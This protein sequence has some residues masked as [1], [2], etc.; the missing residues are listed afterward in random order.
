MKITPLSR[1]VATAMVSTVFTIIVT[2]TLH[3]QP[4][5]CDTSITACGCTIGAAGN[6]MLANELDASQ[7]LTVKNGCIDIEGS[8]VKLTVGYPILGTGGNACAC[9]PS[10]T[11]AGGRS[12]TCKGSQPKP[13]PPSGVGIHVLPSAENVTVISSDSIC[14]WNYAFE[15][16]GDKV[17]F[18]SIPNDSFNLS[19]NNIGVFL[20]NATHNNLNRALAGENVTGFQI[21]GGTGNSIINSTTGGNSQYGIWLDGSQG[22]TLAGNEVVANSLAGIYLGCSS[23]GDVK[24]TIPCTITTTTGNTITSNS[25]DSNASY[26]IALE[27]KSIYNQIEANSA[28]NNLKDDMADGN[29]NC[30]YNTYLNNAYTTKNLHCIQ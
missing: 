11:G 27:R 26:G 24:P 8:D 3:A 16:E 30:I 2:G 5:K 15:S 12:A 9:A 25:V 17:A 20:N 10:P 13:A 29:G 19:F 22:N 7:G 4:P 14:G 21:S 23:K 1:F 6:Y 18:S 28:H